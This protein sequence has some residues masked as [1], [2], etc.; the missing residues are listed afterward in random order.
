MQI[1]V[2]S[3]T[4]SAS[5]RDDLGKPEYSYYFVL[6]EYRPMLEELGTV[7]D[8]TDPATEVD[9][10]Y[11]D[12]RDRGEPC[13]FLSFSPPN[14]TPINLAC[15]TIPVFAWEFDTLPSEVFNGKPRNDWGRVLRHLGAAITHSQFAV[16]AVRRCVGDDFPAVSAPA[17]VW[18]R[19]APL[20]RLTTEP[21]A[22][23][24]KLHVDGMVID[25]RETDLSP[26]SSKALIAA[27]GHLPL[28]ETQRLG[29]SEIV[30]DGVIYTS[31]FN[32]GDGRKNWS[33]MIQAFCLAFRDTPDATLLL[34]LTHHEMATAVPGMLESQ[35]RNSPFACRIVLV[36]GFLDQSD[37]EQ[38]MHA[39][40]YAVNSSHGEGQCLPL[41]EYMSCGIPAVSP[42]HTAMLDYLSSDNGFVVESWAQPGAW[43]QDPRQAFRTLW[44]RIDFGSLVDAYRESYRVAQDD[45]AR[46]ASMSANAVESL[47]KY[48]SR[49]VVTS[50]LREF[51]GARIR[52]HDQLVLAAVAVQAS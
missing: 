7:V 13:V 2:H 9:P 44:Q 5:V 35:Y 45:P 47:R 30:L 19:L 27:E 15:P 31:I 50:Q 10:F 46:Y 42:L 26:Y 24:V 52:A 12:C 11:L 25:S 3:S 14:R 28:P 17:P 29:P 37:Y 39:T 49:E 20:R 6:K 23:Q 48:C 8:V 16:G 18:D 41:M 4:T 51:L 40:S 32:P 34:K 38:L 33:D 21:V 22:R 1:L 43:P 36:N